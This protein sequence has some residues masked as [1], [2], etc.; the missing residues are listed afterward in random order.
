MTSQ[1]IKN[2]Y[3]YRFQF[4][5]N[6]I[7]I[8]IVIVIIIIIIIIAIIIVINVILMNIADLYDKVQQQGLEVVAK[9]WLLDFNY[10]QGPVEESKSF[11]K[12]PGYYHWVLVIFISIYLFVFYSF[13]VLINF[14]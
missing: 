9:L 13:L 8:I 1:V 4:H 14:F 12:A 3:F 7:A 5:Y 11:S 6:I 10:L 2:P